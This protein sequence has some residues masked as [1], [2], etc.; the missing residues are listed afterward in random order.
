MSITSG[1]DV[2]AD[3]GEAVDRAKAALLGA[4]RDD[5]HWCFELEA[6]CT[7]PAEY[8]LMLHYLGERS[9]ELEV[10]LGRYLRARQ[11]EHG[12]WP[13]YFGG[14]LD[15]SCSVKSYWALKLI[16]DSPEAPHMIRAREAILQR[17]GAARANVFTRITMALFGQIPWRGVPFTPVEIMLFPR[18][19]PFHLSKVSYWSRTVMVPLVTLCSLRARAKNPTG[20]GIA[21]LFGAP[22]DRERYQDDAHSL[23]GRVFLVLDRIGRRLER[24]IPKRM[25]ARAIAMAEAWTIERLNGE[26]GLGAIFPAMVNALEMLLWL[27]HDADS[28]PCLTAR[29]AIDKLLVVEDETAYC[30][31]C[32]SPIWD[33]AISCLAIQEA[34]RG[35][36]GEAVRRG[37]DWLL[38]K[39][40]TDEPGDWREERPDL[41][42]GGWAFEY[43]NPHYPDLDDTAMIGWALVQSGRPEDLAAA[44]RAARWLHG[45]QSKNGGFAA[46][47]IDN[48]CYYLNEIPF[49]D[50]GA[51]LDPPTADVT[52][53]CLTFFGILDS[54]EWHEV[55]DRSLRYLAAEQEETGSWFGRWG[56]NYV[57]GTWSVLAGLEHVRDRVDDEVIAQAVRWLE[58][59]Q[60]VDG[61]F[62]ESNDSYEDPEL[63]GRGPGTSFQTAWAMLALIAA[64][65]GERASV[66]M[67]A[68]YLMAT[69]GDDG[70]WHDEWYTAP[71]FPRVFYLRYHGYRKYFPLW[72]LARYRNV[73][74]EP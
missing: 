56:T 3:L 43:A 29:R 7:I 19:F 33:T 36:S 59:R 37:L 63:A 39:Q 42:G 34:D 50:H 28:E 35:H 74:R 49:A 1:S 26:D 60:N 61:S 15:L 69:Q 58:A 62:G 38:P 27:G 20:I 45:M 54:E 57:Y 53:R 48:T 8:V 51:L 9:P 64:G 4:Q 13:L 67:A 55:I 22:P 11:G 72:A 12:G 73:T 16:G 68:E 44:D 24:W 5:G 66:R 41:A 46:F 52:A 10:K 30:Q 70:L 47:D 32:L 18:W 21:E 31:P 65:V 17:G 23:W 2:R 40:L 71:G 25:R 6:D 14:K